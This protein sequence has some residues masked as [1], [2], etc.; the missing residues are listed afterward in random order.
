MVARNTH[1][2]VTPTEKDAR[3]ARESAQRLA[4]VVRKGRSLRLAPEGKHAQCVELPAPAVALLLRMLNDMGRG[5]AVTLIPSD[6]TLTTQQAADLLGV[7]RPF[8]IKEIEAGRLPCRKV[9]SHRRIL[10]SDAMAYKRRAY[11][12]RSRALDE[13]AA[14]SQRLN[15]GY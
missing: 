11:E 8:L 1:R 12:D 10:F 13:L 9:G 3:L 5:Q 6:A 4:R 7:S 14:E 15:L 2:P